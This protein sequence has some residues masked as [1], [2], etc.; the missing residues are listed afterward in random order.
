MARDVVKNFMHLSSPPHWDMYYI[1]CKLC[2]LGSNW[3]CDL[4]GYDYRLTRGLSPVRTR[5]R[6]NPLLVQLLQDFTH[7]NITVEPLHAR[8]R[9]IIRRALGAR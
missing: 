1:I 4:V 8:S 7:T 6:P 5:A 9:E 3:S 2:A